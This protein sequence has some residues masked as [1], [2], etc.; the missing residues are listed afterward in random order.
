[1]KNR[2]TRRRIAA[3]P[4]HITLMS[5][6]RIVPEDSLLLFAD[7][8]AGIADLPTTIPSARLRKGVSGLARLAAIFSLPAFVTVVQSPIGGEVKLLPEIGQALGEL[9]VIQR[10]T[11]DPFRNELLLK[12]IA[13]TGRKTILISGVATELVVQLAALTASELGYR[14]F[15]VIDASGGMNERTERAALERMRASGVQFVSVM[16]LAGE[17]TSDLGGAEG[18]KTVPIIFEMAAAK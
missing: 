4:K 11:A 14:V 18:Q 1:M 17:L 3:T 16:T 15:V 7:L 6:T 2:T 12:Q 5:Q 13:S 8:Q 9:G 10:S